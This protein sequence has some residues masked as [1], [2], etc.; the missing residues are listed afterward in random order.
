MNLRSRFSE[1]FALNLDRFAGEI[2]LS[3]EEK[4]AGRSGV[5][6]KVFDAAGQADFPALRVCVW[7]RF[8]ALH[9]LADAPHRP[10]RCA[11]PNGSPN[12]NKIGAD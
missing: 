6:R 11:L 1:P 5:T 4:A 10:A 3:S 2:R 12:T 8:S 7:R 9:R